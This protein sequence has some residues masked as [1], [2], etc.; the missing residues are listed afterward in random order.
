LGQEGNSLESLRASAK[1]KGGNEFNYSWPMN[2]RYAKTTDDAGIAV[3][4]GLPFALSS[5]TTL[6]RQYRFYVSHDKYQL[7]EEANGKVL[8]I[9]NDLRVKIEPGQMGQITVRMVP[10]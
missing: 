10:K 6:T 1:R 2:T 5:A 3:I 9:D 7:P 8:P 4:S